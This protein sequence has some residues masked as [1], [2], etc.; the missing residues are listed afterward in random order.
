M[1]EKY[2]IQLL[3]DFLKDRTWSFFTHLIDAAFVAD[4]DNR[5]KLRAAYPR[6]MDVIHKYK[7]VEGYAEKHGLG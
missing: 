6:L 7:N 4:E 1:D 2:A 5:V 3:S